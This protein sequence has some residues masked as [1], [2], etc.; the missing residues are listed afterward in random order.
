MNQ[1]IFSHTQRMS[2]TSDH[3]VSVVVVGVVGVNF[4][5]FSTS[6]LK[7]LHRFVCMFLGWTPT[8]FVKIRVL[9][10]FFMELWAILCKFWPI[11]KKSS[12]IKPLIRN[13]SYLVWRVPRGSSF[14]FVQIRL[15]WPIFM[16]LINDLCKTHFRLLL[17]NRCTDFDE[18]WLTYAC[19]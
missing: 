12:S 14:L 3:P 8:K 6:S 9:P 7:P 1:A 13:N 11:L 18:I 16:I 2:V 10:L 17:S 15:L 19:K 5:S 4:F